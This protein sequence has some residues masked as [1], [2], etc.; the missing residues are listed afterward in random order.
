M[1]QSILFVSLFTVCILIVVLSTFTEG[2]SIIGE[3]ERIGIITKFEYVQHCGNDSW[4]W[5]GE[6]SL[7]SR[8]TPAWNFSMGYAA[9]LSLIRQIKTVMNSGHRAKLT[10]QQRKT[11]S[12][13]EAESYY[14]V[15]DVVDIDQPK[16]IN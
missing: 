13:C 10:Y 6:L 5:G 11:I 16:I 15:I 9:P 1:R 4:A 7:L 14:F 3:G 12:G 8:N 2:K